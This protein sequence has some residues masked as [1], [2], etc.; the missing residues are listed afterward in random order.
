MFE[1]NEITLKNF[2]VKIVNDLVEFAYEKK[3]FRDADS[4]MMYRLLTQRFN[5]LNQW[6]RMLVIDFAVQY[7]DKMNEEADGRVEKQE[8]LAEALELLQE[9][10]YGE[11]GD[12]AQFIKLS[13]EPSSSSSS[14]KT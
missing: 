11:W 3:F 9:F 4:T 6:E 10:V 14:A 2:A 12:K 7:L 5:R 13:Q 1:N 8:I